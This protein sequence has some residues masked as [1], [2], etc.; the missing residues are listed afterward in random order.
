LA[1]KDVAGIFDNQG[2][3]KMVS[4]LAGNCGIECITNP[5]NT[6]PPGRNG[7]LH[8]VACTFWRLCQDI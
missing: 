3:L 8:F 7:S 2:A 6:Q 4:T 1:D 5:Q